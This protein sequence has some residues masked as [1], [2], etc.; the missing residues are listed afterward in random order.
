M[1]NAMRTFEAGD[2]SSWLREGN[3]IIEPFATYYV[4]LG[5]HAIGMAV[6]VGICFMLS[7]RILGFQLVV[8]M[9]AARH[10]LRLAW[11]GF[12]L[13]LASGVL[14]IL[15]QPRREFMTELF[16]VKMAVIVWAVLAMRSMGRGLA[17]VRPVADA[18]G[19][20]VELAPWSLRVTALMVDLGWLLAIVS[21]RLVGYTQPPPPL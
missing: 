20:V 19:G 13:N 2:F 15:A 5:F 16:W 12:W 7:S 14:L 6:V 21:G 9:A 11:W 18:R 17:A 3:F 4:L 8:S 10:M 1:W